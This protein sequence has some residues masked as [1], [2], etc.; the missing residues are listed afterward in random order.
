MILSTTADLQKYISVAKNFIF[1]D[2]ELYINKAI[3]TYTRKYV[4]NLHELLED[5]DSGI[6]A[7]ILNEAREHLRSAIANFGFYLFSPYNSIAMDSS[8]MANVVNDHRKNIEWWQLN[9]IRRELLRSGHESMDL[10]LAILEKNPSIFTDYTTNFSTQNTKLL[11]HNTSEFQKWFNI[12]E[13]RQ[14]FLALMP[15]IVQVEDQYINSYFSKELIA[16]IKLPLTDENQQKL[17]E[18]C[19][20]AIV[21]FTIAKVYDEGIFMLD[22]SNLRLKVDVLPNERITAIDTTKKPE[23]TQSAISKN[24]QNG[25]N[26]LLM[27]KQLILDYPDSFSDFTNPLLEKNTVKFKPYNS[28]GVVAI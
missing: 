6:N 1:A 21:A 16:A 17:K 11:V 2:F 27:A 22:A 26:Y 13:S 9:D 3:N 5:Q 20:K 19:Q 8:G 23:Q 15:S 10:L 14:T 25:T 28:K 24:I 7:T 12:F 18:Y 4:G